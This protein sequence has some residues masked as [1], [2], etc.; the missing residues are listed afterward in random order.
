MIEMSGTDSSAMAFGHMKASF[1]RSCR[2]LRYLLLAL[3]AITALAVSVSCGRNS[4]L[5]DRSPV[6]DSLLCELDVT[7][8]DGARYSARRQHVIDSLRGA[9]THGMTR[10]E[11]YAHYGR[12]YSAYDA[13]QFDSTFAVVEKML[14]LAEQSGD[15][16]LVFFNRLRRARLNVSIGFFHQALSDLGKIDRQALD[17]A[18]LENWYEVNAYLYRNIDSKDPQARKNYRLTAGKYADSLLAVLPPESMTALAYA[19]MRARDRRDYDRAMELNR[20]QWEQIDPESPHAATVAYNRYVIYAATGDSTAYLEWVVRSAIADVRNGIM[21]NASLADCARALY[22]MGDIDR[23]VSY[24]SE[25]IN[26]ALFFNSPRRMMQNSGLLY[27]TDEA[28]VRQLREANAS[29]TVMSLM[30]ALLALAAVVLLVLV[31][32]RMRLA[33]RLNQKLRSEKQLTERLRE[34]A[35]ESDRVKEQSI[36]SFLEISVKNMD[37]LHQF[38]SS[39]DAKLTQHKYGEIEDMVKQFGYSEQTFDE[40][41]EHFDRLFLNMFPSFVAEF[42]ALLRPD[43]QVALRREGVLSPELRI[44]AVIRLGI[45]SSSDIARLLGYSLSTIYNYRMKMRKRAKEDV[46]SFDAAVKAIDGNR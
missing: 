10:E 19:E 25:S 24:I 38:V 44:F 27:L 21:D 6:C 31:W 46:M 2:G 35:V 22:A 16:Q 43:Q 11:L 4:G 40:R 45:D 34:K 17:S 9:D 1:G 42:N 41:N 36:K 33:H 7:V 29:K 13:Y 18:N 37:T 23:A 32:S 15:R 26:D 3:I 30:A 28:H 8:A 20:R 5:K 12:L 14:S 39:V